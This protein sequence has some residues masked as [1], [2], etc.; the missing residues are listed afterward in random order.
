MGSPATAGTITALLTRALAIEREAAD[1]YAEFARFMADHDRDELAM[2][3]SQLAR[4][5]GEHARALEERLGLSDSPLAIEAADR[6]LEAGPPSAAAHEWLLRLM[7]PREAL[8]IAL[9]AERRAHGFFAELA[10][11]SADDDVRRLAA[12]LAAEEAA[13]AAGLE[14]LLASEPDPHIDWEALFAAERVVLPPGRGIAKPVRRVK[15]RTAKTATKSAAKKRPAP[16]RPAP[17]RTR[18]KGRKSVAT[19]GRKRGAKRKP[20]R[21][22]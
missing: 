13:H 20:A 18:A 14:R 19:A 2:L 4:L 15:R 9:E 16:R 1:R 12:E 11:A 17:K 6:W 21:R 8:T 22:R 3:F 5:E 7:G 10:A